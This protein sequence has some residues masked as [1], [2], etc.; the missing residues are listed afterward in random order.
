M[1]PS[2]DPSVVE[3]ARAL[4]AFG[5][6]TVH[7][8]QG[9]RGLLASVRLIVGPAFAGPAETVGIPAGDNLGIH[10]LFRVAR[11]G[12]V[13]CIA[14]AGQG[15]FGVLG[16]LL[17]TAAAERGLAGLLIDDRIRDMAQ[18]AAPPSIAARGINARGTQKRRHL[19]INRA[20]ALGVVL[21]RP[22]DWIVCDNDG[23]CVIPA[24]RLDDVLAAAAARTKKEDWIRAELLRGRSTAD[25]LGLEKLLDGTGG[26]S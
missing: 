8:A 13:A 4:V 21:I 11:P 25:V 22:G 24:E 10:A 12:T 7:E 1:P 6:A 18:L 23:V 3:H 14:S 5:V 9:R 20:V 15:A 2:A 17:Q 26:Q 16:D 19:G